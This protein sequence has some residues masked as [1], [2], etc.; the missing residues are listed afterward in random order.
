MMR[1]VS[2]HKLSN[3]P[4]PGRIAGVM[5]LALFWVQLGIA[6][7]QYDHVTDD[8]GDYCEL[9]VQLDRSGDAMSPAAPGA[10][11]AHSAHCG[12][13]T[14]PA[15]TVRHPVTGYLSRAPPYV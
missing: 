12:I 5:L 8:L 13:I 9:C 14:A 2:D 7:H 15:P 11:A 4:G 10:P 3:R 1:T 6:A